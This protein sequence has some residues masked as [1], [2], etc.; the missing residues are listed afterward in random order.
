MQYSNAKKMVALLL[1]LLPAAAR[2]QA[3][4]D[5]Q[6]LVKQGVTLYDQGKYD[7]AV[8]RY[9]QALKLAPDNFTAQYELAMTYG[10]L[11]RN[12]EVVDL[13]R[14]LLKNNA[15]AS[16]NVYVTYGTALDDLKKPQE[17]V[18]IYQA[19]IRKFP[20]S[21]L[22]Y[23]NLG[24]TQAGLRQY[25]EAIGSQQR[26]VRLNPSHASA[27]RVLAIL[28][29]AEGNRVPAILEYV[30]FLQLEPQSRRAAANLTQLDQLL[31]QGVEKTG[32]NSVT[33]NM[34]TEL[35][36]QVNGRKNKP[37]NFGQAD[38]LLT[39]AAALDHDEKNKDK[40][41][42]ARLTEKLGSLCRS[43]AEQQPASRQGFAWEYYAPFFITLEKAGYVPTLAYLIQSSRT[44]Q[45]D[46]QQWLQQ[47]PSEVKE[48]QEWAA[49]Y[50]WPK[51]K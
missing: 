42:T 16:D 31:G 47:H 35:L 22:L 13:C 20:D 27:H 5:A 38:M 28:T 11:G 39:M 44:D 41:P 14:K 46:V 23:Y 24:V 19:G 12:E 34:S 37:D 6:A 48:L 51:G 2:A 9:R 4:D 36:K 30:R 15:E 33:I 50:V 45:A 49:A 21:G 7:E 18:K 40:T 29:A 1:L 17:A 43:L 26:A 3:P 25:D 32:E 8:L 10:A